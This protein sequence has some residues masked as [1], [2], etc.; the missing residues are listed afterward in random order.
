MVLSAL[1]ICRREAQRWRHTPFDQED[2]EGEAK[3]AL[4]RAAVAIAFRRD[5]LKV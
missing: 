4:V 5:I 3:L 1:P 2:L